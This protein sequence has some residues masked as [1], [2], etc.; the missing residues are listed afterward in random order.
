MCK[1]TEINIEPR[2]IVF[3][4]GA[5][6]MG[7]SA[8][9]EGANWPIPSVFHHALLSAFHAKWPVLDERWEHAHTKGNEKHLNSSFRFG[10][11]KTVGVFPQ[12][13]GEL[14][15]P[16]PADVQMLDGES[17]QWCMLQ[18]TELMGM[19]DL[20]EPL[21]RGLRK[22]GD[23]TKVKVPQWISAQGLSNYLKGS[24]EPETV[25]PLFDV[26]SRPGIGINPATGTADAGNDEEG[27][28][29]YAAEY[30]RLRDG[31]SFKGFASCEQVRY[32][33]D[34][35]P[36]NVM[37]RFFEGPTAFVFGGQR[38]VARLDGIRDDAGL[39]AGVEVSGSRIK[40]T[41]L[42]PSIFTGGWLPS[43]IDPQ[44]GTLM[45]SEVE[46]PRRQPGESRQAWRARFEKKPIPGKLVAA[47]VPK[48]IP[49]SGWRDHGGNG[50]RGARPTRLCVPAG[51]VYYFEI[52]EG[53]DP[54]PLVRFLNG[55]RKSDIGAEKGFGF[56]LCGIWK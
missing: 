33:D 49:Y 51:A 30:L 21:N 52:P 5:K 54:E 14:Y 28:K 31:V 47:C 27:G 17:E 32:A 13:D 9:G 12:L 22:P 7:G 1:W 10:G 29:L 53:L 24:V 45:A 11:L 36:V 23:A 55:R 43:W 3:F 4:R 25:P 48:P 50:K 44:N 8:I 15:F 42:T 56:G 18:P 6:P 34:K 2:D 19:G 20:P 16:M 35:E 46:K 41:T 40:W 38:G 26:E 39:P 37:K